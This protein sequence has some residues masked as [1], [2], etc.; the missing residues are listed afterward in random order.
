MITA[1]VIAT[2]FALTSFAAALFVG[3][4]AENP[5]PTILV[6]GLFIML[7]CYAVGLVVGGIAQQTIRLH[8][9]KHKAEHPIPDPYQ[10]DAGAA[11]GGEHR[12]PGD[13]EVPAAA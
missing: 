6:R 13:P 4:F 5:L 10:E 2:C 12:G 3:L 8:I 1:R 11:D 9:E 7:V